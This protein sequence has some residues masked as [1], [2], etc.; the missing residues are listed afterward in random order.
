V[1]AVTV[2]ELTIC[3]LVAATPPTVTLVAPDRFVPVSVISVPP[4]VGPDAGAML[5]S[6]GIA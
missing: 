4:V 3:T 6:V 2:V 5:V 1:I